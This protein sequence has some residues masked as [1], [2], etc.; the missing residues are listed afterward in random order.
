MHDGVQLVV[1]WITK[2]CS[3]GMNHLLHCMRIAIKILYFVASR[4][5]L[6]EL[7]L[8]FD[9]SKYSRLLLNLLIWLPSMAGRLYHLLRY[10][11]RRVGFL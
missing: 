8:E 10:R 7:S 5:G 2:I 3:L 9:P 1:V 6:L 11:Y 4:E